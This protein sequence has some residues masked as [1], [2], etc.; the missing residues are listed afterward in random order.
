MRTDNFAFWQKTKADKEKWMPVSK[1]GTQNTYRS[2]KIFKTT[3]FMLHSVIRYPRQNL[4]LV[5]HELPFNQCFD[6]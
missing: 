1:L 5:S 6:D 2:H 4:L 3:F